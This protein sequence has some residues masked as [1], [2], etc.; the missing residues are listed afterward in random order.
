[1]EPFALLGRHA[2]L[3]F[4]TGTILCFVG[5]GAKDV[6]GNRFLFDTL[7][8]SIGLSI[9]FTMAWLAD[10]W[11]SHHIDQAARAAVAPAHPAKVATNHA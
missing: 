3:V 6:V 5:Q 8:L 11:K 1:M 7:L 2:L 4:A 10:R 9:Q